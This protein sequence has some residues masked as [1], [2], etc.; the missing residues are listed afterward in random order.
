[1]EKRNHSDYSVENLNRQG[2]VSNENV[3]N[4][5]YAIQK[6][7]SV[8]FAGSVSFENLDYPAW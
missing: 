8:R 3:E 7:N 1:M 4:A 2:H 6:M 5:C